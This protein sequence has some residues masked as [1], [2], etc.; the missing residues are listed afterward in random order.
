MQSVCA[1]EVVLS[2]LP[3][4]PCLSKS[5]RHHGVGK[6]LHREPSGG[7]DNQ[8]LTLWWHQSLSRRGGGSRVWQV[9]PKEHVVIFAL[10]CIIAYGLGYWYSTSKEDPDERAEVNSPTNIVT[11]QPPVLEINPIIEKA[12][13]RAVKKPTGELTTAD[14]EKVTTLTLRSNKLTDVKGLEKLTQLKRR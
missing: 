13:R 7:F 14:F 1:A 10:L 2:G 6:V 11:V 3:H 8:P 5:A 9:M 4:L 12:I